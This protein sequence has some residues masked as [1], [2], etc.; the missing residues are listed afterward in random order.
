MEEKP[1][2]RR[3]LLKMG[4]AAAAAA[5]WAPWVLERKG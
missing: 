3:T 2:Y 4:A 1:M 5:G